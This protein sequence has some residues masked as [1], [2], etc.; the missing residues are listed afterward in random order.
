MTFRVQRFRPL[1]FNVNNCFSN[2]PYFISHGRAVLDV[3]H[4]W[5]ANLFSCPV[6]I[7]PLVGRLSNTLNPE[8]AQV[9]RA[10]CNRYKCTPYT[11]SEYLEPGASL[12]RLE[13]D[14]LRGRLSQAIQEAG[15]MAFVKT[16]RKPCY[17]VN[18]ILNTLKNPMDEKYILVRPW[19]VIDP[20]REYRVFYINGQV[21]AISQRKC[22]TS[23]YHRN[24][25]STVKYIIGL[26]GQMI[27]D[28]FEKNSCPYVTTTVDMYCN[29]G[30]AHL[31]GFKPP[32][33][34]CSS[35]TALFNSSFESDP[36]EIRV[37]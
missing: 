6:K 25:S 24:L 2:R 4:K 16:C 10:V 30:L 15:G 11:W 22:Y 35:G 27:L 28:W 23:Y 19:V 5:M 26:D 20:R 14:D 9:Y 8:E 3:H 21:K 18:D 31:I 7:L 33:R 32:P 29:D 12:I 37:W 13:Q 34:W 17:T 36:I 1:V